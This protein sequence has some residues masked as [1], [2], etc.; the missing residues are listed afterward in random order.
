MRGSEIPSTDADDIEEGDTRASAGSASSSVFVLWSRKNLR[1]A[2]LMF[3][4]ITSI[5]FALAIVVQ[6]SSAALRP[7]SSSLSLAIGSAALVCSACGIIA[8]A[9]MLAVRRRAAL[10]VAEGRTV[11]EVAAGI[12]SE[13]APTGV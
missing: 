1:S 7:S 8:V 13:G 4:S 10:L 9:V 12:A 6:Q 11:Q 5:T 2:L 3:F